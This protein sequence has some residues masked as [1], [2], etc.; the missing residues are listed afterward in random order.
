MFQCHVNNNNCLSNRFQ[1]FTSVTSTPWAIKPVFGLINDTLPI[2]GYEKTIYLLGMSMLGTLSWSVVG[3]YGE[4]MPGEAI[5]LAF[6][7]AVTQV[8]GYFLVFVQLFENYGTLI[9]RY[10]ALIE[11]VSPCI[12]SLDRFDDR[13]ALRCTGAGIVG[14]ITCLH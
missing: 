13:G 14:A 7:I 1:A 2:A 5:C 12:G 10:T 6:L 9:A 3:Y 8:R 11:K 4:A